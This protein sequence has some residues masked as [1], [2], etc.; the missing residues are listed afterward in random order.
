MIHHR[1]H[2]SR[3]A[4]RVGAVGLAALLAVV[5]AGVAPALAAPAAA[6][7]A[8]P[9]PTTPITPK[10]VSPE[11]A[12]EDGDT[13][14]AITDVTQDGATV[15]LD[16]E[17]GAFRA[18]FLDERTLRLE[19]TPTGEFTDPA[20]TPQ[21]DPAR[22]ANIVVGSEDFDGASIDLAEGDTI[23]I[24]T[25]KVALEVDRATGATSLT[26]ADGSVIWSESEPLS[27]GSRSAT[28]HLDAVEGEQ[29]LGGGMQNGR[30]IH[31]G[32][33]INIARNF[34]WDDDGYPNAVPY[35]MSSNGYGVLRNTFAAGSYDFAAHTTTHAEQRFDAYYFVGDYTDA[36]DSYTKLTGRPMMPPVY[37]L[38]YGDA[39][40]YNRSSPTYSGSK[41]PAKLRTPQALEI[42]KDF[43]EHDMPGGW[44]L[45]ND[46][47]GCEYQELP[48]TVEAIE[49]ETGLKTGLWT[50]RSLTEQEYEVGE[51][52]V[53]LRKLDV[54]WVGTGYRLALTGCEAAHDGIE[55]YS[56]ARG[57]SLMVEGW[58]GA[59][60]CG[61]QWTGDH[62]GNLDAVRWQV[63]ALTGA[64]NSG[65]PFTTGDVDGIF[66]GSAESYVRDLQWKAFAPALYSMSGW[67]STDKR[68]WL[69]GEQATAIN[70][71]YLQLRQ[72][73]MPYIYSLAAE[74]HR[75]GLPMMR[76]VA[77]EYPNDPGAYSVEANN[78][79]LLGSDY[80][81]AP[82]FTKTT[83]RNGI[84]LPEGDQW[85]DY[86]TGA[87]HDGGQ[88]IN[89]HPA[90]LERLP[91]F[92]RAGAV[93]PQ[94]IVARNAS[95]VPEDS[96][97]T[98]SLYPQGEGE[99]E[100]Y[101]DDKV[102]RAFADGESSTQQFAVTAPDAGK[103]GTVTVE[104]GERDG[105]YDG[106]A[107]ARP[108][109]IEAHTGSAPA[110]VAIDD[111]RLKKAGSLDELE[112]AA[113]GW[114][115][116]ADDAG[117]VVTVKVEPVASGERAEVVLAGTSS[118]GGRDQ[119][120]TAASVAV[121]LGDRVFQ[122][123]Q[124]TVSATFRNTGTKAKDGVVL[125]PVAPE[126]WT[127]VSSNGDQVGTVKA[128]G[129][130]SAEFVFEV[131][132]AAAADLQTVSVEAAYTSQGDPNTVS[133]ANQ[134]YVAYGSLAGAFNAVSITDLAT[135][136]AGNFDGGG[137]TFSAEALA[138]AGVTP[139]GAVAV[140]TGDGAI[141][142]RW[143]EP[144]G[145]PNSVAPEGQ[146]IALS[147]QGTHLALLASAAS[148]GGVNPALE[149]HYTDG[150]TSKQNV[151]FPNRLPQASGVGGASVAVRS[152]G[153]NSATNP[154]VYEYPTYGYQ[155]YSNLVRLNPAKELEYVV[156]PNESRL[157]I[158]DWQVVDQ[159]LPATPTGT[160]F[161][162]DLPWLSATNGW[163]VIGKDVA[164][165]DAAGSPDLP[166]AI[167]YTDPATGENPTYEKGLGV[168]ALSKIT[169]Y[170]GGACEAFTADVGL[171]AGFAGN[172]IFKVDVD[173]VNRYQSRTFTPGFAPEQVNVDLTGVQYVDLV[174]EAP[175]SIN[176]AHGV[177]GDP[178]FSCD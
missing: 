24:S 70:R 81:V 101:E 137:A 153:R 131:T 50:Q 170:V 134:L 16:A 99:F 161:A 40:C 126:G 68:P 42:A 35:Y 160:V 6:A 128:G 43:V 74:S 176:G 73:L 8:T 45:V 23:T 11:V 141:E 69:Y 115:Y 167:N 143:P 152:L 90:P 62:S 36:L 144:V 146:T 82:V 142:Y 56:D 93:V 111:V 39:D 21:G 162:S 53:R 27:F 105:D 125:T 78:E 102:T 116:D 67:A 38:E 1:T 18:T 178:K 118:V 94:G 163:G 33:T 34:D 164:N 130:A 77:L 112:A 59:Q 15:T 150:T 9:S 106:K 29:F 13:L 98:L 117:G 79:F 14:G 41:D 58:A 172:V 80:L 154:A 2:R 138:R 72:Q 95:L 30:S 139:G 166:L 87:V 97:I 175:G 110:N 151:F 37:A 44:M 17:H 155:V 173:G 49:A 145:T 121:D 120:A 147:G 169:Y 86:W 140:G 92:V 107:A 108:Y 132:D 19:A 113:S 54:A 55:Q 88:V 51:A 158:F 10:K 61:M 177:W 31:T 66:G 20:N 149:L 165:K 129:S 28:Q 7:E 22:T 122:G 159:P 64:G 89:G 109:V 75:S 114:F 96:P 135:A 48:E 3:S 148:G 127:L 100:L 47:Y 26:R 168:H 133:G 52:G 103:K 4:A 123:A 136:T 32:A 104:I 124:T 63:S 83:V 156:L 5:G 85:V 25:P 171:E 119:D 60:R 174:V 65:L 71:S 76:S 12:V 91:I 57:T 157:K 84:Y 46:G